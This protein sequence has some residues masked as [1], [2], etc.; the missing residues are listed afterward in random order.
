MNVP[1]GN[2]QK[3]PFVTSI[4]GKKYKCSLTAKE[5]AAQLPLPVYIN[6]HVFSTKPS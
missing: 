1:K 5:V 2:L 4:L 6:L 3:S